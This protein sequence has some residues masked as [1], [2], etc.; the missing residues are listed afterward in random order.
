MNE[1]IINVSSKISFNKHQS[2]SQTL[3]HCKEW[4][5]SEEVESVLAQYSSRHSTNCCYAGLLIHKR[6]Q[7]A[8]WL[9]ATK[10]KLDLS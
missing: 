6:N 8:D 4:N 10:T 5:L 2:C 3:S 7:S 1:Q 9:Y